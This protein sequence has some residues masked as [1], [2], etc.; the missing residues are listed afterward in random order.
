MLGNRRTTRDLLKVLAVTLAVL[1]V[2]FLSQVSLHSHAKGQTE[3]A[4]QVCQAAHYTPP[5]AAAT[6][7][8]VTSLVPVGYVAPFAAVYHE[9]VFFHDSPSR[10][11]PAQ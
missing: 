5:A 2:L 11:P 6:Q 1:S 10:A 8:L 4:C 7:C 3:A 9:E